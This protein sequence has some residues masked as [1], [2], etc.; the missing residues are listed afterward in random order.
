MENSIKFKK[1]E[2]KPFTAEQINEFQ[3]KAT[4]M[5]SAEE[6][7]FTKMRIKELKEKGCKLKAFQ[8]EKERAK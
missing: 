5:L 4:L 7:I 2:D 3:T 1:N 8:D 6:E